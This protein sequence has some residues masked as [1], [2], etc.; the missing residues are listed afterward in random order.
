MKPQWCSRLILILALMDLN[1]C[2]WADDIYVNCEIG[3]DV[4]TGASDQEALKTLAEAMKRVQPGQ[5][6]HMAKTATAYCE[7]LEFVNKS[8]APGKP[9]IVDGHG[10]TISSAKPI[11]PDDWTKVGEDLYRNDKLLF[12]ERLLRREKDNDS[13][14]ISR[15]FFLW[16]GKINFMGRASKGD[17]PPLPKPGQLKPGEWTF[18]DDEFAFYLKVHPGKTLREERIEYPTF[19]NAVTIT[20]ECEHII[21]RNLIATHVVNDGVGLTGYS[22]DLLFDHFSAIECGDDGMSAHEDNEFTTQD[23]VAIG[24]ST[25]ITHVSNSHSINRQ[26]YFKHNNSH[27]IKLYG[28]GT[29]DFYDTVIIPKRQ[30]IQVVNVAAENNPASMANPAYDVGKDGIKLLLQ[31]VWIYDDRASV[32]AKDR[33]FAVELWG[34]H[35]LVADRL[36]LSSVSLQ[37]YQNASLALT[38]SIIGG[39]RKPKISLDEQTSWSANHN[40]YDLNEIIAKGVHYPKSDFQTYRKATGQDAD[41]TWGSTSSTPPD[42]SSFPSQTATQ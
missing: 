21:I 1:A 15:F 33:V 34:P 35:R 18:V 8:G 36:T 41:S 9:I 13:A 22:R 32:T 7:P 38:N 6:V 37:G 4:N 11:N 42:L 23:F 26:A 39:E 14:V 31:N 27:E 3:S 19:R 2:A 10:A 16:D 17:Y 25:G 24:N 5:T 29:H 40:S 28:S 20:G 12:P 30:A